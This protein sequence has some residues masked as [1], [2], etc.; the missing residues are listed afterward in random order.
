MALLEGVFDG[1]RVQPIFGRDELERLPRRLQL[2]TRLR[3]M[4]PPIPRPR[5]ATML[6]PN[7][8]ELHRQIGH[9]LAAAR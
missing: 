2:V 1:E 8:P 7:S 5:R 3:Q 6:Q 4:N 9:E